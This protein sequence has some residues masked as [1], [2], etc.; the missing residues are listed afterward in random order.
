MAKKP[1]AETTPTASVTAAAAKQL[2]SFVERIEKLDQEKAD[3]AADRR[4][5][6]K[7]AAGLGFDAREID[8]IV[9]LRRKDP[10]NTKIEQSLR[11][12]YLN[13]LALDLGELGKWARGREMAES[14]AR[15]AGVVATVA[16]KSS[17]IV[18]AYTVVHDM[19][20]AD[21]ARKRLA[22]AGA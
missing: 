5:V 20:G 6:L 17:Q 16:A 11:D 13:A 21:A 4:E 10:D 2:A 22:E 7:E 1:K 19:P 15:T 14:R 12:V 8:A 18:D 3:I 9:A